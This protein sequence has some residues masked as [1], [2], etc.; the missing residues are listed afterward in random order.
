MKSKFLAVTTP[1]YYVNSA[2][3]I[4]HLYTSILSDA[5]AMWEKTKGNEVVL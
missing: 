3:H 1:I 5:V 4:G 2:P